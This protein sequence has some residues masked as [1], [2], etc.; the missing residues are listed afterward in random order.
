MSEKKTG[1]DSLINRLED[2]AEWA[3]E[4]GVRGRG[5]VYRTIM[6]ALELLKP[7]PPYR[8]HGIKTL[9]PHI[10]K[11]FQYE[12]ECGYCSSYILKTWKACPICGRRI[13]WDA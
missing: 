8:L 1:K 13:E 12:Y 4:S 6:D 3:H 11:D 5:V 9:T 7:E 10:S 2:A